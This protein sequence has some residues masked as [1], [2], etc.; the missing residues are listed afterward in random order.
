MKLVVKE[1]HNEEGMIVGPMQWIDD[2][3]NLY[4]WRFHQKFTRELYDRMLVE[5]ANGKSPVGS[6]KELAARRY[7]SMGYNVDPMTLITIEVGNE[8]C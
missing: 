1:Q 6:S 2:G 7:I 3:E 4:Y 5:I 8:I